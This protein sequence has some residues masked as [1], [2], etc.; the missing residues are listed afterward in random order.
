MT[1][2]QE[3]RLSM[4]LTF[5]DYQAPYTAITNA[6]P[7]YSANYTIFL[8]TIPQIQSFSEQQKM[9]KKGITEGKNSL[10]ET[11]IVMAADYA[12]KLSAYAKFTNN[13]TLAQEVKFTES[14]LRQVADTAVKDYAQIVYDRAQPIVA[15]LST[16]GITAANQTAMANAITAYNASIGKPGLGRSERTQTTKQLVALFKTAE[17]ALANMDAAV[18]IV[19][20]TQVNFY[21]G[22]KSARKVIE[23]GVGKLSV[24]GMVSD[25]KTGLPIKG[26]SVSFSR[27][28]GK[29]KDVVKK[30]AE[31]GGFNIKL[32]PLGMY[33]VTLK[34]VGYADKIIELSVNDGEMSIVDVNLDKL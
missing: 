11:L 21:N 6:L 4:Y 22:Y 16:Y 26:A 34:K 9:S 30:T 17:D 32:L 5:K 1:N 23:T 20:L 18:E 29:V 33:R 8:N 24:K 2:P 12:R 31:K 28:G 3:S 10:K 14:K 19:R 15:L 27:V 25:G 13:A 7:N